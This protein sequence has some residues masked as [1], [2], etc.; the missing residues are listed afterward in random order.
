[1]T[2]FSTPLFTTKVLLG[3]R[4]FFFDVRKTKEDK[5]YV[6]ITESSVRDGQKQRTNMMI[7]DSEME[8]FKKA[9]SS[10]FGFVETIR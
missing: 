7:F 1:M 5:P 10:V 3:R 8:D 9:L 2:E 6:K 4:T